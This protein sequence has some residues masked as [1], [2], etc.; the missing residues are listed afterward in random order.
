MTPAELV[1]SRFG[2]TRELARQLEVSPST[3]QR[4]KMPHDKGGLSGRVPS[5]RMCDLLSLAEKLGIQLTADELVLGSNCTG[6]AQE[7]TESSDQMV[8]GGQA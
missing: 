8:K 5:A 6:N 3:V 4:W 2:G 1:I 7:S